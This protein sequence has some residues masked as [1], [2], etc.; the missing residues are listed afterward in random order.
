MPI[1][2]IFVLLGLVP[3]PDNI[4]VLAQFALYGKKAGV[5]V[6]LGPC[7]DLTVHT[8]GV[9]LGV[10]VIFQRSI[11]A[12]TVLKLVGAIYLLYLAWQAFRASASRFD[13]AK[14]NLRSGAALYRR[15]IIMSAT[16][17]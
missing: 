10:A 15:G 1:E 6:T 14:S 7:T 4:F 13:W 17:L 12:F 16:N 9:A 5:L 2:S 11:V 3:G 8:S